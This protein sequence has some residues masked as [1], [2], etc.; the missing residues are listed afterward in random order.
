MVSRF[1]YRVKVVEAGLGTALHIQTLLELRQEINE[2][3]LKSWGFS[4]VDRYSKKAGGRRAEPLSQYELKGH[5][6][7]ILK[8]MKTSLTAQEQKG[9]LE[10]KKGQG[11]TS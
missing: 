1:G 3:Q 10:V 9:S 6:V 5:T 4:P 8:V 7:L 11:T 2:P